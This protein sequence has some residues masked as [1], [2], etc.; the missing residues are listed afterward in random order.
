M[1]DYKKGK[2]FSNPDKCCCNSAECIFLN[3]RSNHKPLDL[4]TLSRISIYDSYTK[5]QMTALLNDYSCYQLQSFDGF[6]QHDVTVQF[7]TPE[8]CFTCAKKGLKWPIQFKS[9]IPC[10]CGTCI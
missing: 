7:H 4:R 5:N 2:I 1:S 3:N 6:K 10:Q 9:P 8:Y